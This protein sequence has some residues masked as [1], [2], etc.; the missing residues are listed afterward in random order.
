MSLYQGLSNQSL[1]QLQNILNLS[2]HNN[3]MNL[4]ATLRRKC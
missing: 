1:T 2:P 4:W 3:L